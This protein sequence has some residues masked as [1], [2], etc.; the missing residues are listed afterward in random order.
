MQKVK[1]IAKMV[2]Y[3]TLMKRYTYL[4]LNMTKMQGIA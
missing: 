2:A 3:Y 1:M 4:L